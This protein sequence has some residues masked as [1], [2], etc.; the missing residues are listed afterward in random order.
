M[1]AER[2]P[3]STTS[4]SG[5]PEPELDRLLERFQE[6]QSFVGWGPEDDLRLAA[7]A[8]LFEPQIA[9]L[10][11]DFYAEI[12][13][14]PDARRVITGGE[15]QIERLKESLRGWLQGLLAGGYDRS[16]LERRLQVGRRHVEIGLEQVY[17]LAALARLRQGLLGVLEEGWQ[18]PHSELP[19]TCRALNKL[20]D[21]DLMIIQ[22]SYE[23]EHMARKQR[24][25]RLAAVGQMAG[26]LAHEL[27]NPLNVVKTSVYYLLRARQPSPEKVSEHL[28][29][30]ERQV[31]VANG[32]ITALANFA[33]MPAPELYPV[34]LAECLQEVL[35]I[36]PLP[37]GIDLEVDLPATLPPVL[38]DRQQL[39]IV[40][41]NLLRNAREAMPEGG[42]LSVVGRVAGEHVELEV[43]DTGEGIRPED[44]HR[45]TEPLY[46]TKARGIGLG[47]ALCRGILEKHRGELR[48]SSEIG[49]GATFTAL[50]Q[51]SPGAAGGT[52]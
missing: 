21:L 34:S 3:L 37:A 32:V 52:E 45:V 44:L 25:E 41:R 1:P 23:A 12:E 38:A 19:A 9:A 28:Q 49:Q 31:D 20:L 43:R 15:P 4:L 7:V 24:T 47:L 40:L 18:G 17:A 13:R 48:V 10:V 29:R 36:Q 14:H 8:P 2:S 30:I 5:S 26:G 39:Q 51:A 35:E 33:R 16:Y 50:L 22:S 6:L 11:E 46:T 42:K 27:R